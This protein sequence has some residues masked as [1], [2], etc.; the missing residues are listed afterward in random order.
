VLEHADLGRPGLVS[1]GGS[2]ELEREGPKWGGRG[3][4]HLATARLVHFYPLKQFQHCFKIVLS[5]VIV[6]CMH[7]LHPPVEKERRGIAGFHVCMHENT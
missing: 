2:E 1:E 5:E 6:L 4:I 3:K 7:A